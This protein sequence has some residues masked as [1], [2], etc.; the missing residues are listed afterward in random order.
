MITHGL[1]RRVSVG[2]TRIT[3]GVMWNPRLLRVYSSRASFVRTGAKAWES[4][5]L[6]SYWERWSQTEYTPAA[7][8][9]G[10]GWNLA[11]PSLWWVI[12]WCDV[13][14]SELTLRSAVIWVQWESWRLLMAC[15]GFQTLFFIFQDV[16]HLICGVISKKMNVQ[17]I[18]EGWWWRERVEERDWGGQMNLG[19]TD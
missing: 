4:T 8:P 12:R 2:S 11:T 5:F 9:S 14:G 18:T 7:F 10:L 3:W 19:L 6:M 17:P 16:N 1:G 15:K 13:A